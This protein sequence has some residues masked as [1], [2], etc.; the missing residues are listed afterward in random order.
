MGWKSIHRLVIVQLGSVSGDS[1]SGTASVA[2]PLRLVGFSFL[3]PP[4]LEKPPEVPLPDASENGR[5]YGE[6]W[7]KYP[8]AQSLVP[9]H[10]G[11]VFKARC[12]FRVIMNDFCRAAHSKG[13]ALTLEK[14]DELH[15]RLRGWYDGLPAP[16]LAKNIALPGHLQLQ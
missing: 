16:L 13:S 4:L 3:F 12:Q 7:V 6:I 9:S 14:A 10:F 1:D 15:S 5:F 8:L 2:E 11:H